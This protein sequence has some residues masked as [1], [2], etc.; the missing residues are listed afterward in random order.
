M[1]NGS[2]LGKEWIFHKIDE[3]QIQSLSLISELDYIFVKYLIVKKLRL[4]T[5]K[6]ICP[7]KLKQCY[8]TLIFLK[9]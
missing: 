5:L 1:T 7:Q 3:K 6:I 8:P 4:K 2:V 9:I